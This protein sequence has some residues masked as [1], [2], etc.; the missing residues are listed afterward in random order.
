MK[1]SLRSRME[2]AE[3]A[4]ATKKSDP[5]AQQRNN[6]NKNNKN[7]RPNIFKRMWRGLKE[8][9]SELKKVSWPGWK[10]TLSQTGVVLMVVLIFTAVLMV[11]Y[12]ALTALLGLITG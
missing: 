4:E 6:K 8:M 9:F 2:S 5:K 7:K 3:A 12:V 1:E 11:I 10:K